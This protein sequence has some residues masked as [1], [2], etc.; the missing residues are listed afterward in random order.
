MRDFSGPVDKKTAKKLLKKFK[1]EIPHMSLLDAFTMQ[2]IL[3]GVERR[4]K[5]S[6]EDEDE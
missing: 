2:A 5:E 6:K 1:K 4:R 3:N